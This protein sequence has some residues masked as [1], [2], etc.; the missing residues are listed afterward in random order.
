MTNKNNTTLC[1]G[2]MSDLQIR[3]QEHKS[4]FYPKSFTAR[5]DLTKLVYY[6]FYSRIEEAIA[7]EKQ[8]KAG[9]RKAKEQLINS[10]NH[11]WLDLYIKDEIEEW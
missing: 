5:Y 6:E 9:S 4:H 1:I 7:I 10:Q 8:L 2:V 11:E 3:V